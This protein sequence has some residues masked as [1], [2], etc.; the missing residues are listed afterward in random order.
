MTT[1]T[2]TVGLPPALA[3]LVSNCHSL[4]NIK[5]D[6][7]NYLLW[8]TQVMNALRANGY[9]GYLDGSITPPVG[10]ILDSSND[11]VTNPEFTLWT[12]IDNQLLS[13]L[14]AS[15]A[16]TT[17]THVLG[18][19]HVYQVWQTLEQRFN[20]LSKTHIHELK[21]RFYSIT[22]TG[23]MDSYLDEIR[24]Y[25]HKLEAVG[26]HLDD[27]D[28]VFCAKKGLPSE[29]K[30][31]KSALNAKG[32]IMF[33]ELVTILRYEESQMHKDE[34]TSSTKVFLAAQKMT[35]NI[36]PTHTQGSVSNSQVSQG[37]N[38]GPSQNY[39]SPMYQTSNVAGPFYPQ[40]GYNQFNRNMNF[41][42]GSNRWRG[43][44]GPGSG[45]NSR[46]ECQ[47]CGKY[48]H[49]A[50]YCHHRQNLQYQPSMFM[51]SGPRRSANQSWNNGNYHQSWNNG[52]YQSGSFLPQNNMS[53]RSYSGNI[54]SVPPQ[55]NM[56]TYTPFAQSQGTPAGFS[57]YA[58]VQAFVAS[59]STSSFPGSSQLNQGYSGVSGYTVGNP[60]QPSNNWYFDSGASSH[61]THDLANL[62]QPQPCPTG[63]GI[64]VGNGSSLPVAYT[65][66]THSSNSSQGALS[67]GIVPHQ[68]L[69]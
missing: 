48:N 39:Q 52:N 16:P 45:Q 25:A 60:I 54:G 66:Q 28:L 64:L 6:S 3:F 1:A 10:T 4:V 2:T 62:S 12:L 36:L 33:D 22:M 56:F 63:D 51:F 69:L 49:T 57:G 50:F 29:Y 53:Q 61:V 31:V 58:P 40:Q 68:D 59:G 18:L 8:R 67:T 35:E 11:R 14:T 23:T 26:Y 9:L 13:C 38:S 55:A 47:I 24:N 19:V 34:G 27:D 42:G 30:H 32:D 20:S 5:L 65:G 46:V 37:E 41:S 21:D 7:G 17:L 43:G 44:K 15:L